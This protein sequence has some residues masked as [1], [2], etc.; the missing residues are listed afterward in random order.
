MAKAHGVEGHGRTSLGRPFN[1][2]WSTQAVSTLGDGLV[3]VALP[4]LA[5]TI[6]HNALLISGVVVSYRWVI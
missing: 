4:L 6:T 1:L 5:T 3:Y 2:L